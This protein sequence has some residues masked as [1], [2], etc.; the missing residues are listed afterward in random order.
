MIFGP[1]IQRINRWIDFFLITHKNA[2][3]AQLKFYRIQRFNMHVKKRLLWFFLKKCL[4]LV[5]LCCLVAKDEA[6][7]GWQDHSTTATNHIPSGSVTF[8]IDGEE[9]GFQERFQLLGK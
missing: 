8:A 6:A 2:D 4:H 1:S 9:S 5:S 3:M 7:K